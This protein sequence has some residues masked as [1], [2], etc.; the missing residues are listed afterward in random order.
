[1]QLLIIVADGRR[2]SMMHIRPR[3]EVPEALPLQIN[4]PDII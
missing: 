4:A 3:H 1:M 2:P